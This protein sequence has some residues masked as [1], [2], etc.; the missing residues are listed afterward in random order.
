MKFVLDM[1]TK[2]QAD[3]EN[4]MVQLGSEMTERNEKLTKL[5]F[6]ANEIKRAIQAI[7]MMN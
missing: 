6:Q 7:K 4:D 5:G 1:L 2:A 3:V